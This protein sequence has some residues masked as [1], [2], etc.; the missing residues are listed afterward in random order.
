MNANAKV[1]ELELDNLSAIIVQK[2]SPY[3]AK[4]GEDV[5]KQEIQMGLD[6]MVYDTPYTQKVRALGLNKEERLIL[7]LAI[8]PHL[9]PESLDCFLIDHKIF[10]NRKHTQFG[11]VKGRQHGGF[12][13]TLETAVFLL[14]RNE[15]MAERL[16][17]LSYFSPDHPFF[18]QGVLEQNEVPNNEPDLS[19]ILSLSPEWLHELLYIK[20]YQPSFSSSFPAEKLETDLNWEELVLPQK[21]KEAIQEIINWIEVEQQLLA[22]PQIRKWLS[23]G[24]KSLFYGKP[25]TGKTLTAALIGKKTGR[26]VYRID[27][28]KV[29]SKFI[30]ET[31]KNLAN[32]FN[33]AEHKNWILFFDEADALFGKRTENKDSK[34]RFANQEVAYLLQRIEHY[35]GIVFLATNLKK[36]MDEAFSRRLQSAIEFPIPPKPQ[37]VKLWQNIFGKCVYPFESPVDYEKLADAFLISGGVMVNAFRKC[38]IKAASNGGVIK[39]KDLLEALEKEK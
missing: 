36:N 12:I 11:G 26:P 4:K 22:D 2:L 20:A 8:A 39:H 7:A 33:R 31:E 38:L 13:P 5:K 19:R 24:Y 16:R 9:K 35:N 28:S 21:T 17:V 25:G 27:L 1:I 15:S 29:I 34:D 37:R 10:K 23:P 3:Y 32:I 30:G 6:P 18:K 14:V